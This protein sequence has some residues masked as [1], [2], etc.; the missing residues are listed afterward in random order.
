MKPHL[1]LVPDETDA[2]MTAAL[3]SL[4]YRW[5]GEQE[6]ASKL[7]RKG[8]GE[9]TVR[10]VIKKL[11]KDGWIDDV[12]FAETLAQARARRGQGRQRILRELSGLGVAR[13]IAT[14]AV[15]AAVPD[16]AERQSLVALCRKKMRMMASR[17]GSS[18]LHH[19]E[20]RKKLT[21][22]L[23]SRGYDYG[24]VSAVIRQ[25]LQAIEKD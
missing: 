23:L 11:Q 13:G 2:C 21:A 10:L 4:Q 17:H 18:S 1:T 20:A 24:E 16:E 12:R 7:E 3:R 19:E 25:E 6:L 5:H 9:N 15:N 22:Y 14:G 8:F